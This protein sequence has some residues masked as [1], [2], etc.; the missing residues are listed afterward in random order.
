MFLPLQDLVSMIIAPFLAK[1]VSTVWVQEQ[2]F[3]LSSLP[4]L[5]TM[6]V[7]PNLFKQPLLVSLWV[8]KKEL[9][10]EHLMLTLEQ[11]NTI[12]QLS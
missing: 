1:D 11:D 6:R 9:C 7:E 8:E 3:S 4:V 5:G 12:H 10:L 2:I